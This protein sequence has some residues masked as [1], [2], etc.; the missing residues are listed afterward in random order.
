MHFVNNYT[1]GYRVTFE[2]YT[3]DWKVTAS[4]LNF[5][6]YHQRVVNVCHYMT[7]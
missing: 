2:L 7:I 1:F 3:R 6:H 5:P 4:A